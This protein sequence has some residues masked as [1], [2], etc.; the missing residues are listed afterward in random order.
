MDGYGYSVVSSGL[1]HPE[2]NVT[3]H[4]GNCQAGSHSN[5]DTLKSDGFFFLHSKIMLN[6]LCFIYITRCEENNSVS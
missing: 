3:C 2:M 5:T 6:I 1:V 4:H